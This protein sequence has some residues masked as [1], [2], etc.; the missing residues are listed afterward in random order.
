MSLRARA[1]IVISSRRMCANMAAGR[2]EGDGSK[3]ARLGRPTC[4][5][6]SPGGHASRGRRL[7]SSPAADWS[8]LVL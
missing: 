3:A 6:A 8:Q 4:W 7:N 5:R 2:A 1:T